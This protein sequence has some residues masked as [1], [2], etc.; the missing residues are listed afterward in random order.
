MLAASYW[1][2]LSPALEMASSSGLYGEH[3]QYSYIPVAVGFFF[4]A[5]FVYGADIFLTNMVSKLGL[6]K[7]QNKVL[8]KIFIKFYE[9]ILKDLF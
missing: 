3:G 2:L 4:G 5:L 8:T 1:S 6:L 7:L 9:S